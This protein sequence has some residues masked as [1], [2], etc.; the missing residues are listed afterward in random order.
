M[1]PGKRRDN[2]QD[3]LNPDVPSPASVDNEDV[4]TSIE[5]EKSIRCQVQLDRAKSQWSLKDKNC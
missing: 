5:S 3:T 2:L 1:Q 4:N